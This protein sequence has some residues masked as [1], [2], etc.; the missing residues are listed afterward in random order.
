MI[1]SNCSTESRNR[2]KFEKLR[3]YHLSPLF[4]LDLGEKECH[5]LLHPYNLISNNGY[6][7]AHLPYFKLN[8]V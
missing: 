1:G 7:P 4:S 2:V 8:S 5:K 6:G 3:L